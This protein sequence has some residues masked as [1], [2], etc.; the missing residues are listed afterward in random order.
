MLTQKKL[1]RLLRYD[2]ETGEFRWRVNRGGTARAGTPAG[3]VHS[4]EYV[5]IQI[6]GK[7][8]L[9]HRLA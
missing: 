5:Y 6:N 2:P 3:H 8:Y 7:N 1:K 4:S 9:A